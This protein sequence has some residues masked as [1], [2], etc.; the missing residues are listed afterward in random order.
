MFNQVQNTLR[1]Q[2]QDD[3]K[4]YLVDESFFHVTDENSGVYWGHIFD[5]IQDENREQIFNIVRSYFLGV[6]TTFVQNV[7]HAMNRVK[8]DEVETS[9]LLLLLFTNP[10][11]LLVMSDQ[12]RQLLKE[13]RDSALDGIAEH[14]ERTGRNV[15]ERMGEIIFLQYSF[16]VR[17]DRSFHKT[18]LYK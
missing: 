14:I 15:D 8:L 2:G 17:F 3:S 12:T 1:H 10:S 4:L 6:A 18:S 7:C 5:N 9:A 16:G 13:W 11:C